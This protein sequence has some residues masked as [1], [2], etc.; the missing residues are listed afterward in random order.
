M[1][2]KGKDH[3]LTNGTNISKERKTTQIPIAL[4]IQVNKKKKIKIRAFA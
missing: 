4:Q 2:G 3:G 1:K